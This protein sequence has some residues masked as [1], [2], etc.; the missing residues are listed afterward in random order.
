MHLPDFGFNKLSWRGVSF[1]DTP[2]IA[3]PPLRCPVCH[4]AGSVTNWAAQRGVDVFLSLFR[5]FPSTHTNRLAPSPRLHQPS[6]APHQRV[7]PR[8]Q[9]NGG[10]GWRECWREG[11]TMGGK[12]PQLFPRTVNLP[13]LCAL[14]VSTLWPQTSETTL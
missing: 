5:S 3:N 6:G 4:T 9:R 7:R 12:Q 13:W 2:G 14:Q 11:W 10:Q 8:V 1:R